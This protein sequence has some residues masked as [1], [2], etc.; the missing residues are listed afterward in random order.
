MELLGFPV[1]YTWFD[2]LQTGFRGAI[3]ACQLQQ[4]VGEKVRMVG[5]LITIKYVR[6]VNRQIMHFAAFIDDEG[7]F[8]DTV[9]F[10]QTLKAYPFKGHGVYLILGKVVS[11]FGF[12][13][14]EVEKMAVLSLKPDPR[15]G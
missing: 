12:P 6:T 5:Q 8:F 2:L 9:H 7:Q 1:G 11:E 4:K 15:G 13:S 3:K 10:P 14:I